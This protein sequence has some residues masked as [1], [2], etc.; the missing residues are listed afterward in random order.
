M[1]WGA[2]FWLADSTLGL[3]FPDRREREGGGMA[4]RRFGY[5][6]HRPWVFL[7]QGMEQEI[8]FGCRGNMCR[9]PLLERG[10]R[11][12]P[13]CPVPFDCPEDLLGFLKVIQD[14]PPVLS[15]ASADS[16][17]ES[18]AGVFSILL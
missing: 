5:Y 10:N 9:V 2:V 17:L 18:L 13:L 3:W 4:V 12:A 15:F 7:E 16:L 6:V 11:E 1:S 8:C 14:I